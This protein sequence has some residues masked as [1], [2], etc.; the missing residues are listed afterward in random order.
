[1]KKVLLVGIVIALSSVTWGQR[2]TVRIALTPRSTVGSGEV[3]QNLAKE[4]RDITLTLD[5]DKADYLLEADFNTS[6]YRQEHGVEL[7]LFSKNGDAVFHTKTRQTRNAFKDV[8]KF[9][10][11]SK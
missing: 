5:G 2:A 9:L 11:V 3:E 6:P 8:C 4:C 1:M 10:N 7:T